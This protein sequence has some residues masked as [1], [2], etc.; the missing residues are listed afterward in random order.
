[1]KD[2][3]IILYVSDFGQANMVHN[4]IKTLQDINIDQFLCVALDEQMEKFCKERDIPCVLDRYEFGKSEKFLDTAFMR[5]CYKKIDV[6][7]K[8]LTEGGNILYCDNDVV[9][10]SDPFQYFDN[11][12]MQLQHHGF[13]RL[14]VDDIMQE[15]GEKSIYNIP[16]DYKSPNRLQGNLIACTGFMYIRSTPFTVNLFTSINNEMQSALKNALDEE[17]KNLTPDQ[18]FLEYY[19]RREKLCKDELNKKGIYKFLQ[20]Y[21]FPTRF[22][23]HTV[24]GDPR[25]TDNSILHCN[26]LATTEEKIDHLKTYDRWML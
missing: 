7:T 23:Y 1:M 9:F 12:E 13:E 18:D 25:F 26:C 20:P 21:R 10:Y 6:I 15:Y 22:T 14:S 17:I 19:F 5:Y 2:N 11:T 3:N 16:I 4:S 24:R 8:L